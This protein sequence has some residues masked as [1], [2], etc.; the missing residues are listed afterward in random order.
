MSCMNYVVY[1]VLLLFEGSCLQEDD[2]IMISTC[3]YFARL[4]PEINPLTLSPV[5][6]CSHKADINLYG[7]FR[8]GVSIKY[9][10][11]CTSLPP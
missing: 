6:S 9:R 8:L 10:L 5:D 1:Y 11:F 2:E 3:G 4:L 7:V